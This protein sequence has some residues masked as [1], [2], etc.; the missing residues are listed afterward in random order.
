MPYTPLPTNANAKK[1][2]RNMADLIYEDPSGCGVESYNYVFDYEGFGGDKN[3]A[4]A[5]ARGC[6]CGVGWTE[7]IPLVL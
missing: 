6:E 7:I 3:G 1:L 5:L 2:A 4:L